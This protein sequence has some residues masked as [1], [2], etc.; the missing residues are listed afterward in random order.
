MNSGW[1]IEL[2]EAARRD[3]RKIAHADAKRIRIFL[4]QRL[5]AASSPRALDKP[6]RGS[7]LGHLWRYRVG[8]YRII[9]DVQDDRLVISSSKSDIVVKSTDRNLAAA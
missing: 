7:D 9:C 2:T 4:Q 8:D 3:L 6:L 5:G 1:T